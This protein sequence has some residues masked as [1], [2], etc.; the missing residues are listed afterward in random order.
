MEHKGYKII[1]EQIGRH[2]TTYQYR[3]GK[4]IVP[5]K[6]DVIRHIEDL[7]EKKS[8]IEIQISQLEKLT[9]CK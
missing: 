3:C 6:K 1:R 4:V 7:L 2:G 9:P 8:F 5:R